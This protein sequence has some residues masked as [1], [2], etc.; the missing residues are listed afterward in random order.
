MQKLFYRKGT[1]C[2]GR[3]GVW[4]MCVCV[5]GGAGGRAGGRAESITI[6]PSGRLLLFKIH[7]K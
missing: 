6:T 1:R 4:G 7:G 3:G 2:G 5:G